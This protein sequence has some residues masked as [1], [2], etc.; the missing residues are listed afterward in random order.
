MELCPILKEIESLKKI[1]VQFEKGSADLTQLKFE[2]LKGINEI[3]K[4]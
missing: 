4:Q 2:L 1:L 3:V